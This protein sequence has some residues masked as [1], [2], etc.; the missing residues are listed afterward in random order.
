MTD[1]NQIAANKSWPHGPALPGHLRC[2]CTIVAPAY[3]ECVF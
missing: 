1:Q 3:N 2:F